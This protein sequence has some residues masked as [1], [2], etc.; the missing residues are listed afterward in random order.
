MVTPL[1][2]LLLLSEI[3]R[4]PKRVP[5]RMR[6]SSPSKGG[7]AATGNCTQAIGATSRGT[8][9][10]LW[11]RTGAG[12]RPVEAEIRQAASPRNDWR[13]I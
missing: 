5:L 13:G 10:I 3:H 11:R 9:P 1:S 12:L 6:A 2:G 7:D 4:K 8:A